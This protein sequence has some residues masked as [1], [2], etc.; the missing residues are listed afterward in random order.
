MLFEVEKLRED[1]PRNILRVSMLAIQRLPN[2]TILNSCLELFLLLK[3]PMVQ[4]LATNT[5]RTK[6]VELSSGTHRYTLVTALLQCEPLFAVGT[7]IPSRRSI[8]IVLLMLDALSYFLP[9]ARIVPG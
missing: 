6:V 2:D 3:F 7:S 5:R 9:I 4:L 8:L 1:Q